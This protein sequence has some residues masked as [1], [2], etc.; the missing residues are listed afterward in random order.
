M[1]RGLVGSEMCIRDS[2]NAEYMGKGCDQI[3][4]INNHKL[5]GE[6]ILKYSKCEVISLI[7]K[8]RFIW[9]NVKPD[10]VLKYKRMKHYFDESVDIIVDKIIHLSS[11]SI[12]DVY[13]T[14]TLAKFSEELGVVCH[15]LCDYFCA[16]HYYRW[17]CTTTK[18]MKKH[19]IYEKKLAKRTKSCLLY[20][21]PSPRDL[22]TSR[23][24]SSA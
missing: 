1:Q 9:G 12:D 21:S 5:M 23:M 22:S 8:N 19:M 17:H 11:L 18:V 4:I 2:I 13:Y 20:T 3:L 16:P 24:P 6:N 14:M 15:F 10:C 7:N